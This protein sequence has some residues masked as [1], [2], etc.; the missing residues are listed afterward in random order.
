MQDQQYDG[1]VLEDK[2]GKS[3]LCSSCLLAYADLGE[4]SLGDVKDTEFGRYFLHDLEPSWDQ[5]NI[6]AQLYQHAR[7]WATDLSKLNKF[8]LRDALLQMFARDEMRIWQL[9][10]GWGKAPEG[11]GIGDGG[12]AP[13]TSGGASPAPAAKASKPKG[14]GATAEQPVAAKTAV[15]EAKA[16]PAAAKPALSKKV[17]PES[18]E[19][20]QK[21]LAERR[22][23][24]EQSGY[25]PKYSDAELLAMA[26]AG[27]IANDRF[28]IRL[29]F[30][31]P[32]NA[33][34]STLGFRRNSG[35][36]P[37]WATTFDMAEAADTDPEL[38]ACIFG[39]EDYSPDCEFSLVIIDTHNL[40]P[41]AERQT[42]IPTFD[43]M[44]A[45]CNSEFTDEEIGSLCDTS[46]VLN[47]KCAEEYAAFMA[48]YKATG[49]SVHDPKLI[50]Q[51]LE[52][53]GADKETKE[54]ILLRHK[55]QAELGA[56]PLFSG[57]GLTKVNH[58]NRYSNQT[59]QQYGVAETVTFERDPLTIKNLGSSVAV[60]PAKPIK[61]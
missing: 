30:S 51:H 12:L 60:V 2:W 43:N 40:P 39:I 57:N 37:Y 5:R 16:S 9:T 10:D 26:K 11:N 29:V 14:G 6:W 21:I 41:Q 31:N 53:I 49:L 4:D 7:P 54:K 23:Q 19:H 42:F 52:F 35:R 45:F 28:H 48:G 18:L 44:T 55:V 46:A 56:N 50:K 17:E 24:I 25:K 22:K 8:Q 3:Y 20:A 47:E 27:D 61:G 1:V 32:E 59:P 58:D 34:N 36:A 38:L 13:T 15:H 33:M